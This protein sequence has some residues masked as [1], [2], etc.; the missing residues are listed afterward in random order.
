MADEAKLY[1]LDN[2]AIK[3]VDRS[4]RNHFL[5]SARQLIALAALK[6]QYMP[7]LRVPFRVTVLIFTS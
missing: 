1:V 4:T 6:S 3:N 5:E 2:R 7:F